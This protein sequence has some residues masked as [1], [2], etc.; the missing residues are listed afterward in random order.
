MPSE[1]E[2]KIIKCLELSFSTS[3]GEALSA[4]RKANILLQKQK[5][6]W[7]EFIQD[8]RSTNDDSEETYKYYNKRYY[9][10]PTYPTD[11][12]RDEINEMFRVVLDKVKSGP[13]DFIQ[14][15]HDQWEGKGRLSEKQLSALRK[16]YDNCRKPW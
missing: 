4:I 16:F 9:Q 10:S 12:E 11:E 13:K 7:R 2:E 5:K 15:L 3:D 14:S 8:Q 1:V 6:N